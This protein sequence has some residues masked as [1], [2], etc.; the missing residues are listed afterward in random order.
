[1]TEVVADQK[2]ID[3]LIA[4]LELKI[5]QENQLAEAQ[6]YEAVNQ[7]AI[8]AQGLL[9]AQTKLTELLAKEITII[10]LKD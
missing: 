10:G 5:Q 4:A 9:D 2:E 1:M 7:A 3:D 8:A 6:A